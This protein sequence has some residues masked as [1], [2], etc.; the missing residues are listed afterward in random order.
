[1]L[2]VDLK[3]N[4]MELHCRSYLR[5]AAGHQEA[6]AGSCSL[7]DPSHEGHF[8]LSWRLVAGGGCQG[9]NAACDSAMTKQTL[10]TVRTIYP[11]RTK[12]GRYE[13][14]VKPK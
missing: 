9:G 7:C 2:N 14:G 10:L 5:F 6:Q 1:M 3:N 11:A 13:D 8:S 12:A 4:K